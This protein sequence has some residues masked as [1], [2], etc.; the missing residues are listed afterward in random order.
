MVDGMEAFTGGDDPPKN[1]FGHRTA[2]EEFDGVV[3]LLQSYDQ[4]KIEYI[5]G[6]A[7]AKDQSVRPKAVHILTHSEKWMETPGQASAGAS[8]SRT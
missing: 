4:K 8:S 2:L 3:K 5:A 1:D 6:H 7:L